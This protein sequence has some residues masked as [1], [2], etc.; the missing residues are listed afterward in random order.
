[1][2]DTLFLEVPG[3]AHLCSDA[4]HDRNSV[5]ELRANPV[6]CNPALIDSDVL[7]KQLPYSFRASRHRKSRRKLTFQRH[8]NLVFPK[9]GRA[10]SR[11][12]K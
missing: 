7:A 3:L 1:M 2:V 4:D 9:P 11:G 12:R 6:C 8:F 10:E 5:V